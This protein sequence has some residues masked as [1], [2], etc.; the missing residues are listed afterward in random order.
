MLKLWNASMTQLA[1][2][3]HLVSQ[4][5]APCQRMCKNSRSLLKRMTK[6]SRTRTMKSVLVTQTSVERVVAFRKL[7]VALVTQDQEFG[8]ALP[9]WR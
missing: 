4:R 7:V 1:K 9:K 2:P 3:K 6:N 8:D 5:Q